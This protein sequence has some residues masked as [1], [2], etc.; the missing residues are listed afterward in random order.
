[1]NNDNS[2][3]RRIQQQL[4]APAVTPIAQNRRRGVLWKRILTIIGILLVITAIAGVALYL[5]ANSRTFAPYA[6]NQGRTRID[7]FSDGQLTAAWFNDQFGALKYKDL[8]SIDIGTLQATLLKNPIILEAT[9]ERHFP[10]TLSIIVRER[11]PIG[12]VKLK[13]GGTTKVYYIA[14][15]GLLFTSDMYR[16]PATLPWISGLNIREVNGGLPPV[17]GAGTLADILEGFKEKFPDWYVQLSQIDLSEWIFPVTEQTSVCLK[18]RKSTRLRF[19]PD[20]IPS[21][22][23]RLQATIAELQQEKQELAGKLIDLDYPDRV[24]ISGGIS[25]KG[26]RKK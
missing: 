21:Q 12:R 17:D 5:S 18:T 19:G 4:T 11:L 23:T 15:D 8:L 22:L 3:W 9:I 26:G 6:Q 20:N 24:A 2:N 14:R 10:R 25:E 13:Q 1:M 7:F 16:P